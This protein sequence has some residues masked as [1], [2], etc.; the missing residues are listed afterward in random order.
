MHISTLA[1][2]LHIKEHALWNDE[3]RNLETDCELQKTNYSTQINCHCLL[4]EDAHLTLRIWKNT[5]LYFSKT[6]QQPT[7][8]LARIVFK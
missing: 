2:L 7:A 4:T 5:H 6:V 8:Q 1:Y 3:R